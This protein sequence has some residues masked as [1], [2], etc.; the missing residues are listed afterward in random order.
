MSINI[1]SRIKRVEIG[2]VW[3]LNLTC[4]R[5]DRVE[6]SYLKAIMAKM[7]FYSVW[8]N[9]IIQCVTNFSYAFNV[10]GEKKGFIKLQRGIRQG[11]PLSPY[12]FLLCAE[13]FSNLLY[14]VAN[15]RKITRMEISSRGPALSHLFF[16]DNSL[17]FCKASVQEAKELKNILAIYETISGQQINLDKSSVLFSKNVKE[18]LISVIY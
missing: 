14:Q 5:Y 17:V 2:V 12:F 1:I 10:N 11:D 15:S 4:P 13:G 18:D 3:L 7:G 9:W 6:W 16:T 8:I